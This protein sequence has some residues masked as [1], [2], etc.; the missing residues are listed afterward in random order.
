MK[1]KTKLQYSNI[2]AIVFIIASIYLIQAIL[3]FKK[4]ET[5]IRYFIIGVIVVMNLV[6]VA[7]SEA[8][9]FAC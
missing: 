8:F 1:K 9:W 6:T 7:P 5:G 3:L 4:I 2:L